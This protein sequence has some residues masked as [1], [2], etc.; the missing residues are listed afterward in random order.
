[1]LPVR[2]SNA[3]G[4][5]EVPVLL[6]GAKEPSELLFPP[7]GLFLF[8]W[9]PLACGAS[10]RRDFGSRSKLVHLSS[11]KK[12]RAERRCRLCPLGSVLP[13]SIEAVGAQ[14]G[15]SHRVHDVAV[16]QEVLQRAGIDAV[17]RQLVSAAV[18]QHVRMNWEGKF[19]QFPGPADHFE[20]P[21]P[22]HRPTALGIED[23]ATLQVLPPQLAQCP[24]F[25]ASEWVRAI[26]TVLSPAHMD[27]AA[28]K[29]DHIP[30]QFA[31]FAGA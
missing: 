16:T 24:D 31:E 1:M 5:R 20:E 28:I 23:V 6:R 2:R 4:R 22:S 17:V 21:G 26:D 19:G 8:P 3:A 25:L 27:A 30:G 11:L 7:E 12:S 14:L 10:R 9:H 15:I 13:E 18:A 29:L